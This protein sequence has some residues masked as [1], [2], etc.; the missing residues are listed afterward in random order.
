[1]V[2][3]VSA[4]WGQ[5]AP[6]RAL[7]PGGGGAQFTPALSPHNDRLAAVSTDMN[8]GFV[9]EDAGASWR[10]IHLGS[11]PLDM[12][13][14]P[15][16]AAPDT[17]WVLMFGNLGLH[18]STDRGRHWERVYPSPAAVKGT[19]YRED[20]G[21]PL[22]VLAAAG[23]K[24]PVLEAVARVP[25]RAGELVAA[26]GGALAVSA[27][28]GATWRGVARLG[29]PAQRVWAGPGG[30]VWAVERGQVEF[31]RGGRLRAARLPPGAEK[32]T[33]SAAVWGAAPALYVLTE[34]DGGLWVTHDEGR[35][36]QPL[37]PA[38]EALGVWSWWPSYRRGT[39]RLRAVAAAGRSV[40]VSYSGLP[41]W[42]GMW[43]GVAA[44]GDG[45]A[46]WRRVWT[47]GRRPDTAAVRDAWITPAL[48]AG[49]G[50]NP[51]AISVD[52]RRPGRVLA[53]DFGRTLGST[54]GGA[55]WQAL[56]SRPAES[57]GGWRSTGLDVTTTYGVHFDPFDARRLLISY[58]D[59]GPFRSEDGGESWHAASEGIPAAW[60]N[61]AYWMVFDPR[62]LDER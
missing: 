38:V 41:G 60:R 30:V 28:G 36:W 58:T 59:I 16:P 40:Y 55:H 15:D 47:D 27:D 5:T 21:D 61:S 9:T 12:F 46:S 22:L 4:A 26:R 18:R 52:A 45:G 54:D 53:T 51:L 29:E 31:W 13:F 20:E 33:G 6:W 2:W 10:A 17:L 43:S 50:E 57:G 24:W 49:F 8:A 48:G 11:R 39:L 14:D 1:M 34:P 42:L 25:D 44:S 19:I 35:R 3:C 7:G 32:I 23:G 37:T 62:R 56:Y